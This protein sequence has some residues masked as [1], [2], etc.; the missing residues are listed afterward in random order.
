MKEQLKKELKLDITLIILSVILTCVFIGCIIVI[1]LSGQPALK[2]I[3]ECTPWFILIGI[4]I[5]FIVVFTW[6]IKRDVAVAMSVEESKRDLMQQEYE[7]RL[8]KLMA[9]AVEGKEN[10]DKRKANGTTRK[11]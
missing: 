2:I 5:L 10:P 9:Q 4:M 3:A 7:D 8:K 11:R 1:A 6:T